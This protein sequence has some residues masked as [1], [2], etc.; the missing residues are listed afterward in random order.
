VSIDPN[1]LGSTASITFNEDFN[2]LSLWNGSSG[3][4]STNFWYQ[5]PNGAGSTITT[6]HEQEWYINANYGPTSYLR[7]WAA[8]NGV[9]TLTASPASA[10]TQSQIGGAYAYTSGELNTFHSFAQTYGYFEMR[11][12]L[13]AGQ[14]FWP[15]FWLLPENGS[16][17][18][19]LDVLEALSSDPTRMVTTSHSSASGMLS[20]NA[21]VANTTTGFHTYGMDW[22][23]D[24]I[25]WYFDGA[26]VY[27][28]ATPADMNQPMYMIVNLAVGGNFAGPS[29]GV[30]SGQL[31][32]DWVRA[33]AANNPGGSAATTYDAS[34]DTISTN[35]NYV[36]PSN[37]HNLTLTGAG[38][39]VSGNSLDNVITSDNNNNTLNG[40]DGN[41][42]LIAGR[43]HDTLTGGAGND[44]FVYTQFPWDTGLITDFTPGQD[45]IDVRGMLSGV[46]YTGSD[47]VGAGY[48]TL[49]TD[50]AGATEVW[51]DPDGWG[52]GGGYWVFNLANV[53]ASS[54][55]VQ[56]GFIVGAGSSPNPSSGG[57]GSTS[58][59]SSAPPPPG[60][61][62]GSSSGQT[63]TSDN[64]GDHWSGT[65]ANETFYL[66]RGGDM[67][68]SG[69]G[70]DTFVFKE[71]PWTGGHI[72]G[73]GGQ[74]VLDLAF[75]AT[76]GYAGSN[77]I[78]DGRVQ[79]VADGNGGTQVWAHL[80][81]LASASG[82]WLVTTLDG[83]S[84]ANLAWQNGHLVDPPASG[85]S[86]GGSSGGGSAGGGTSGGG[87]TFTSDNGGDHW[88]G[89][90]GNDVFNLG[91]GGDVVTGN[92]GADVF[93][94]AEVPW[95]GG[96]ITDFG[97]DDA[98]D[99]SAM[100]AHYGYTGSNPLQDGHLK[101]V[102][103]GQ[104]GAQVWFDMDG[105]SSGSGSWLVTTLDHVAPASLGI[106][107]G[108]LTSGGASGSGAPSP[109]G[110]GQTF[111]S[112]NAGDH[113]TGT[114]GND[115]F[116][117]GR[118]G[119][120]I[121]GNGGADTFAFHEIPWAGAEIT[122]F[123]SGDRIDLS[124]M[125]QH[126]GY[127]TA[128]PV[129]DGRLR[130]VSDGSG[131]SQIWFDADGLAGASGTWQL[132]NL[133]HFGPAQLHVSGAF[134]AA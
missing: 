76:Y 80:D 103:D 5:D 44:T 25:T 41:D 11:A 27:Q 121:A 78:A 93:K 75:L 37:V 127:T 2:A 1:N 120:V 43:G 131:G 112:D 29:D 126:Y 132:A 82:S 38:Q 6:T 35:G 36:L 21:T 107:N 13:P 42:T 96:H 47:P 133:D 46:G 12:Q 55:Q 119:D 110:S 65:S 108:V 91:R 54:L 73:F 113:W 23:P 51:L 124:A 122:D 28:I 22:E 101:L 74:D 86:G 114:S 105:L 81:G 34:T 45:Q 134:I 66:G 40:G 10:Y 32:V 83:I 77:P 3:I 4:W 57:S 115:M 24:F 14:G 92:G 53:Q 64:N 31:Q 99:L 26:K 95:A 69:G 49:K 7:P 20:N 90:S 84:P 63:F 61:S 100:F 87:Q 116:N 130:I 39:T 71:V 19:E 56:N 16:W 85:S 8:N 94:F 118:G 89:T 60:G 30:S 117:V 102:S 15:A 33:Y 50:G 128:D 111:T 58:G 67:V 68:S 109:A 72:S 125:F 129:A 52:P 9:L 97:A 106:A 70:T 18:P 48:L 98:L 62:G 17:P 79:L 88:T 59:G 123:A 104:D